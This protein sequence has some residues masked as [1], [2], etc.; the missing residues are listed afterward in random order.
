M[1]QKFLVPVANPANMGHLLE[2]AVLI[3][4]PNENI[5]VYPLTVF[6]NNNQ[7]RDQIDENQ[8][9]NDS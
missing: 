7:V 5:P 2:F 8:E 6:T 3:K 4:D 1:K 9:A